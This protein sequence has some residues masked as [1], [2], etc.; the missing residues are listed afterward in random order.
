VWALGFAITGFVM[1]GLLRW[2]LSAVLLGLGFIACA[3]TWRV[4]TRRSGSVLSQN[5]A[6]MPEAAEAKKSHD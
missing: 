6:N 3:L 2:N 4:L 5:S 1:V